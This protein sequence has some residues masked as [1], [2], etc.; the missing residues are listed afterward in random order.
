M[1]R[2][3]LFLFVVASLAWTSSV[4]ALSVSVPKKITGSFLDVYYDNRLKYS[5]LFVKNFTCL[6]WTRK[7]NQWNTAFGVDVVIFQTVH[8]SRF[9]AYWPTKLPWMKQWDGLCADV[10][11][12]VMRSNLKVFLSCEFVYNETDSVSNELIMQKRLEIMSNL[13][14]LYSN[15]KSFLG[16]YFSSEAYIQPY[17]QESFVQYVKTLSNHSAKVTPNALKFISPYG[18]HFAVND[19]KFRQQLVELP[20]DYIAYQDEVGALRA[21]LPV[22]ESVNH[23][24][25]L[26]QAHKQARNES[27]G[28]KVAEI[29]ANIE[30]FTWEGMAQRNKKEIYRDGDVC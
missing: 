27:G 30:S 10:V 9:G 2:F 14:D 18:T 29:W 28:S 26:S 23:F 8:D 1:L 3:F 13:A 21:Q 17:F 25:V 20:V 7:M 22:Y 12:A 16:W 24:E 5:N 19:E 4:I 11:G 6:D 15:E